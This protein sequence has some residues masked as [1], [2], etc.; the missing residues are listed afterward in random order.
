VGDRL[1]KEGGDM[2]QFLVVER[3]YPTPS[4]II[5]GAEKGDTWGGTGDTC[6]LEGGADNLG[7]DPIPLLFRELRH[8]ESVF[9]GLQK[10][11]VEGIEGLMFGTGGRADAGRESSGHIRKMLNLGAFVAVHRDVNSEG[12]V[13]VVYLEATKRGAGSVAVPKGKLPR[14]VL[15]GTIY[16]VLTS[17]FEIDEVTE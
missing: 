4:L 16:P 5:G 3:M 13:G 17:P 15:G 8:G 7:E 10:R 9:Q 14:E 12:L 2:R 1:L 11:G 6:F